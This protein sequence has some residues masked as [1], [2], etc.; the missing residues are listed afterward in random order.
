MYLSLLKKIIIII[1]DELSSLCALETSSK[2]S[3]SNSSLT[4][5]RSS[6]S[7]KSVRDFNDDDSSNSFNET[8]QKPH[9][10]CEPDT[11]NMDD[12]EDDD[13]VT[14]I[15]NQTKISIQSDVGHD[16]DV[17]NNINN[18]FTAQTDDVNMSP[19]ENT[20]R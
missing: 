18:E 10:Q 16:N 7:P 12:D 8:N 13:K 20:S 6:N 14:Q 17:T 9:D 4:S 3:G 2:L 15:D 5:I 11:F 19:N 1:I